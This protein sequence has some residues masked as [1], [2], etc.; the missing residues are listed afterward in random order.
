MDEPQSSKDDI[1][2]Y[3]DSHRQY[4][5]RCRDLYIDF[6][7][8]KDFQLFQ[9][10]ME[11]KLFGSKASYIHL[12]SL[13]VHQKL[14]Y[15]TYYRL[16]VD[17]LKRLERN[18]S[19]LEFI[20]EE[21]SYVIGGHYIFSKDAEYDE[22]LQKCSEKEIYEFETEGFEKDSL[23]LLTIPQLVLHSINNPVIYVADV[24]QANWNELRDGNKTVLVFDCGSPLNCKK[25]ETDTIWNKHKENLKNSD[26]TLVIS[27]WDID[28]YQC[29]I[30]RDNNEL[31]DCFDTVFCRKHKSETSRKVFDNLKSIC[32]GNNFVCVPAISHQYNRNFWPPMFLHSSDHNV[33]LYQGAYCRNINHC[34]LAV[35]IHGNNKSAIL[36]GDLKLGQCFDVMQKEFKTNGYKPLILIVPHHGGSCGKNSLKK[37]YPIDLAII[38]VGAENVYGHPNNDILDYLNNNTINGIKRTDLFQGDI[39]EPL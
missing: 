35:F 14:V 23:N 28:H 18:K 7:T 25:E 33:S 4:K 16:N 20:I 17:E 8:Q 36:T 12:A 3:L 21:D 2:V 30:N 31:N 32:S 27:H 38:S 6:R 9:E 39:T 26:S 37:N 1:I 15:D 5:N 34:G 19:F 11:V 22:I 13:N 29:L 24:G 10:K